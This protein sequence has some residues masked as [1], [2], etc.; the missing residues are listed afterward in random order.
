MLFYLV[1]T[2]WESLKSTNM[3]IAIIILLAAINFI[4][5]VQWG[6]R[7]QRQNDYPLWVYVLM[8]IFCWFPLIIF[9]TIII[10]ERHRVSLSENNT[11]KKKEL[12]ITLF[13]ILL[14]ILLN[15]I[16]HILFSETCDLP[17]ILSLTCS[18]LITL[19]LIKKLK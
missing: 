11:I 18:L 14:A 8:A 13:A 16:I 12:Y 10:I 17:E 7:R 3:Y 19:F 9:P 15:G 6:I 4:V 5:T 1:Y 2:V